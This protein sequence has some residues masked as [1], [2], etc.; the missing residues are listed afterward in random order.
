[1]LK[2][3]NG[4]VVIDKDELKQF[5]DTEFDDWGITDPEEICDL[6][7]DLARFIERYGENGV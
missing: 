6:C 3:K 2:E 4:V 1:M 5:L 7:D